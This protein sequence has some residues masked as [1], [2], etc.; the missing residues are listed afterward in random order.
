MKLLDREHERSAVDALVAAAGR[1]EGGAL[2]L[3]GEAG[4]GLSALIEHS[5]ASAA[6]G[7]IVRIRGAMSERDIAFAALHQLCAP[8]R[9]FDQIA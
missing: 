7:R 3:R 8:M 6:G 5:V 2:V 4:V 9:A 1:G